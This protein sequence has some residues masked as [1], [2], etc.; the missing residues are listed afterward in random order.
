[1][2]VSDEPVHTIELSEGPFD[3][4]ILN[5]ILNASGG[6]EDAMELMMHEVFAA[7]R[8]QGAAVLSL[9]AFG[10]QRYLEKCRAVLDSYPDAATWPA[11]WVLSVEPGGPM[12]L[13]LH[14]IRGATVTRLRHGECFI[15]SLYE[16]AHARYCRLAGVLPDDVFAVARRADPANLRDFHADAESRVDE[17]RPCHPD[18]VSI[19]TT[20]WIGMPDS[21]MCGVSFTRPPACSRA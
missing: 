4:F 11:N 6:S 5:A 14:C 7:I 17:F 9:D 2:T 19:T 13:Q 8:E 21:T 18:V 20:S 12:S 15:G 3:T 1:M 16:N 10:E